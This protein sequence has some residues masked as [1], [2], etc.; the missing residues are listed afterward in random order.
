M[1]GPGT[2]LL[3]Q[4]AIIRGPPYDGYCRGG[5]EIGVIEAYLCAPP[6][7]VTSTSLGS[8][9]DIPPTVIQRANLTVPNKAHERRDTPFPVDPVWCKE[10][11]KRRP[12]LCAACTSAGSGV[13]QVLRTL[14]TGVVLLSVSG[15]SRLVAG[16]RAHGRPNSKCQSATGK[17][18]SASAAISVSVP[19]CPPDDPAFVRGPALWRRIGYLS[20]ADSQLHDYLLATAHGHTRS[21]TLFRCSEQVHILFLVARRCAMA[22]GP[23]SRPAVAKMREILRC[24]PVAAV[25]LDAPIPLEGTRR[26]FAPEYRVDLPLRARSR[27]LREPEAELTGRIIYISGLRSRRATSHADK[28]TKKFVQ[29]LANAMA[30]VGALPIKCH[31]SLVM[32]LA[33]SVPDQGAVES[34]AAEFAPPTAQESAERMY[35]EQR[36]AIGWNRCD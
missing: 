21:L 4:I 17:R 27:K 5:T 7:N 13:A 26:Q 22:S 8:T 24:A 34:A 14:Q 28:G 9:I 30:S 3:G 32:A 15:A 20:D 6:F 33:R 1:S 23:G 31:E 11:R 12:N 16:S 35:L 10:E 2:Q 29:C 25:Y 36:F 18:T 19:R